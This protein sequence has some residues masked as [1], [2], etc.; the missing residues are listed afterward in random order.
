[1]TR[2]EVYGEYKWWPLMAMMEDCYHVAEVHGFH[3]NVPG[4]NAPRSFG[5]AIALLHSEVSEA[6]E[7]YR[8]DVDT[9]HYY[10]EDGKPEGALSELAD[11]L[12][13]TFDTVLFDLKVNPER[14]I[15]AIEEKIA[16]NKTRP[17]KHG[18]N[19]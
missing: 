2:P 18:K 7:E 19:M 17:Y 14:F 6:L 16:Y 9:P 11:V 3:E 5:D 12:I 15:A 1:V 13:R 8:K 4:T 10:R